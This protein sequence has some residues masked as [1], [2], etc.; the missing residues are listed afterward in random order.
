MV[1]EPR[2]TPRGNAGC[3]GSDGADAGE[4]AEN[5]LPSVVCSSA[6]FQSLVEKVGHMD[7]KLNI[8]L[9]ALMRSVPMTSLG[10]KPEVETVAFH[11]AAS[12]RELKKSWGDTRLSDAVDS[13]RLAS[14]IIQKWFTE[15][16]FGF[17]ILDGCQIFIHASALHGSCAGIVGKKVIMKV[18]RDIKRDE[19]SYKAVDAWHESTKLEQELRQRA[20]DAAAAALTRAKESVK[21]AE[22]AQRANEHA[23]VASTL[24]RV[25]HPPGLSAVAP[26]QAA[27]WVESSDTYRIRDRVEVLT[28]RGRQQQQLR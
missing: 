27:S 17:A 2:S 28:I 7:E 24:E 13:G 18:I 11:D 20:E 23:N 3:E 15:K 21:A 10:K 14:G 25:I 19:T 22:M 6:A 8:V 4:A 5:D 9:A 1:A 16:A 26:T 12:A